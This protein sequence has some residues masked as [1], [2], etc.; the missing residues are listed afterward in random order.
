VGFLEKT[1]SLTTA[2]WDM[3]WEVFWDTLPY[4]RILIGDKLGIG[5][6]A[7][8]E[9]IDMPGLFSGDLYILHLG[10]AGFP[11]ATSDA[12]MYGSKYTNIVR[13]TFIHELTHVWQSYKKN[14]WVM[15]RSLF[16][17]LC[18]DAYE[19]T[20]FD[21]EWN[22]YNVEQQARIVEYWFNGGMDTDVKFY[23]HIRDQIRNC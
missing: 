13:N 8:M 2:E 7:W 15:T 6:R 11:D 19:I 3:A 9:T 21:L 16:N 12:K 22:E 5:D 14:Q 1:R 18:G 23:D 20:E 10:S 4:E 17:Q